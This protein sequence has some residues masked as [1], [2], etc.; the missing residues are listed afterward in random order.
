MIIFKSKLS[1]KE[2]AEVKS[3]IYE[4]KDPFGDFYITK[5]NLR[6]FISENVDIMID[7]L[8]KGDYVAY[9]DKGIAFVVGFSD[10]ANRKY[11]K[12]LT[13][14]IT[15]V[16]KLLKVISWNL[17]CDLYVKIKKNNPLKSELLKNGFTFLG[18][19]G[20]ETLLIRK[21]RTN[22]GRDQKKS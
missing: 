10:K 20:R 7:C 19:R 14:E 13:K 4:M 9:S 2:K 11:L 15:E 3:L 1:K 21:A 17:D 12:I 8:D 6:L 22:V 18:G 5:N 16:D